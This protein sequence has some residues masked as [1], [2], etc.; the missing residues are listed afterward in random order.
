M[1][2]GKKLVGLVTS[3]WCD[4]IPKKWNLGENQHGIVQNFGV[5]GF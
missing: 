2:A 1:A 3:D 5:Y 4:W